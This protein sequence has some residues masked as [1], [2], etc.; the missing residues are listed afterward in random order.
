MLAQEGGQRWNPARCGGNP[1]TADRWPP[2]GMTVIWEIQ[3]EAADMLFSY[4]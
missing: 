1:S 3:D 4:T 2:E